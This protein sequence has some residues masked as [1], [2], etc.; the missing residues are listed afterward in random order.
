MTEY[1]TKD[2]GQHAEYA[3]G[4][5]RDT[6]DGKPRFEL[7]ITK[8]QPYSEQMVTRYAELLARGAV[9]YED[10]NWEDGDSEEELERAKASLLRHAM[11]LVAGETDE[12]HAAAVWFNAQ[13]I[14]YFRWRIAEKKK[15][16]EGKL[17]LHFDGSASGD[18]LLA[19]ET[20]SGRRWVIRG[21][22]KPNT[23]FV[24]P[25]DPGKAVKI[26]VEPEP[27][28]E[29]QNPPPWQDLGWEEIIPATDPSETPP[30]AFVD[31]GA[32]ARQKHQNILND[33]HNR[34]R[35]EDTASYWRGKHARTEP[36][37]TL[38]D[39][40]RDEIIDVN[41]DGT[42]FRMSDLKP[43]P[44]HAV[45]L[46]QFMTEDWANYVP[47]PGTAFWKKVRDYHDKQ[48]GAAFE[49]NLPLDQGY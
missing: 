24:V 26:E 13:A 10:R 11:Q 12:D 42:P 19:M 49:A 36:L 16:E 46:F 17:T 6:Q 45:G 2:S 9:K 27:R 31:E 33:W 32:I 44:Q 35:S 5:R 23:T 18:H 41:D 39:H 14:E 47:V 37:K 25:T 30:A 38:D 29:V 3:S 21:D 8:A 15:A 7:M 4:M 22:I 48:I 34:P 43:P 40:L 28:D 20:L 1:E